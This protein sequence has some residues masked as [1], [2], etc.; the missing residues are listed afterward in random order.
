ML[1]KGFASE[2]FAYASLVVLVILIGML[3]Y[4]YIASENKADGNAPLG[5]AAIK[6]GQATVLKS[7]DGLAILVVPKGTVSD[8]KEI[9]IERIENKEI[10]SE[11]RV[12]E[13]YKFGPSG[14]K[15]SSPIEIRIGYKPEI[16]GDCPKKLDFYHFYDN[17]ELKET[18]PSKSVYCDIDIAVFEISSFSQGY[19]GHHEE[20]ERIPTGR[21]N[22]EDWD[23]EQPNPN[24]FGQTACKGIPKIDSVT[25]TTVNRG[26][27]FTIRGTY[28][29]RTVEFLDSNGKS[30]YNWANGI[31]MNDGRT[32]VNVPVPND[33]K[34]GKYRVRTWTSRT[35]TSNE[36]EITIQ[37]TGGTG[38]SGSGSWGGGITLATTTLTWSPKQTTNGWFPQLSPDGKY[39]T[40]G[41][42]ENWV[43]DLQTGEERSM[44]IEKGQS[45]AGHWIKPDAYTFM[46]FISQ[47]ENTA[48]RYEVKTGEWVARK[49]NDNPSLVAGNQFVAADSHWAS[50]IADTRNNNFRIAYDNQIIANGIGG[51]LSISEDWIVHATD[52]DNSAIQVW[53]NRQ[54]VATHSPQTPLHAMSVN[55]GYITYGGYGPV[56]G[57]NPQGQDIDLT[58]APWG[59]EGIGGIVF[60]NGQP[61]AYTSTWDEA[62]NKGFILIRP[63]GEKNSIVIEAAAV[64]VHVVYV[65][66]EFVVA[67]ND[68]KGNL[69]V[70][71]VP[72]DAQRVDLSNPQ[73][74]NTNNPATNP[75]TS[76]PTPTGS[77]SIISTKNL[78]NA[79]FP[80]VAFYQG[81]LY[82]AV[83]DKLYRS[84]YDLSDVALVKDFGY[85]GFPRLTVYNN[86]LWMA[87]RGTED[88][89]VTLW[90]SD[91]GNIEKLPYTAEGN[92]PVAA[93]YGYLA[94]N[95]QGS[96][97]RRAL[98]GG[99]V[100]DVKQSRPTGIN[101]ILQ[102][103]SIVSVDQ[104]IY[105]EQEMQRFG[106]NSYAVDWG[107]KPYVADD[108][109]VVEGA[110][111]GNLGRFN[112]DA[113]Y[114]FMVFDGEES[115]TPHA[116]AD[117]NGNYAI[118]T[119]GKP[120]VRVAV[121]KKTTTSS[122][123]V[124]STPTALADAT[125]GWGGQLAYNP[126]ANN[127]LVVSGAAS[128][129]I[130][131]NDGKAVT[132]EFSISSL[133]SSI[134]QGAPKVAFAP[135]M[136]KYLVVWLGWDPSTIYGRFVNADGT[137][138]G[139]IFPIYKDV[140]GEASYF[141]A[142]SFL[143]YD[144]K[145]KKFV[146]TWDV[147]RG[148]PGQI[149]IIT[150]DQ[151]GNIGPLIK[152]TDS[153]EL[154]T[155]EDWGRGHG[156]LAVNDDR[157]EYCI[158][159]S[160]GYDN[161][162]WNSFIHVRKMNSLTGEL[163]P[164]T[165]VVATENSAVGYPMIAY[166]SIDKNY[167]VAWAG[168]SEVSG[169]I[170]NSC[171]GQDVKNPIGSYTGVGLNA[172]SYNPKSNTYAAIGQDGDDGTN[173]GA[174]TYFIFDSSGKILTNGQVFLD[175]GFRNGNFAPSIA[176]N[177]QDGTFA[178]TSSKDYEIARFVVNIG[179][180]TVNSSYPALLC[181]GIQG[182]LCPQGYTCEYN[183]ICV[184][185]PDCG[186]TCKIA[187]I[188]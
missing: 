75:T 24:E 12:S 7:P 116:A 124:Q 115:F 144:Q 50:W 100:T 108:L 17:N 57:I 178:A 85:A 109:T 34:Y 159:Y 165:T 40:Y 154:R 88:N 101:R 147:A 26:K 83:D 143:R 139:D 3:G 38:P 148:L 59:W 90:R 122:S 176:A 94:F 93:G 72:A 161:G 127:W 112:N 152:A 56:H 91:T 1:K 184:G 27:S 97:R 74:T 145:N 186:G 47:A 182:K 160:R 66:N 137:F 128:G 58:V 163:G 4:S 9:S 172:V 158:V 155:T 114:Q 99:I 68:D 20:D 64:S 162:I 164:E 129:R 110:Q 6:Q 126:N 69:K 168:S 166:N 48:D 53:R 18:V 52:P 70:V 44:T 111:G 133:P 19:I 84:S 171:D 77:A 120:G 22:C 36:V 37:G 13:I 73:A 131:G 149:Y 28:L 8:T 45:F 15:F 71:K 76:N 175:S 118:A 134:Q 138:S 43:T 157:D 10:D 96:F 174:N 119:W 21:G 60:V 140:D 146:L 41:F 185:Q 117:G 105:P 141:K 156:V 35:S 136:N 135:D 62:Q 181:G 16:A 169:R 92:D 81:K 55:K 46:N 123:T 82:I 103:G 32:E 11:K 95:S 151:S 31:T 121:I 150:I 49:T 54:K 180:A 142:P 173:D 51:A 89:T 153:L 187:N 130:M 63:W 30:A 80:D 79:I 25:P 67:F 179:F 2:R 78:G 183:P 104:T 65:N 167:F 98:T 188:Q 14:A 113:N 170:I 86:I 23:R 132:P 61:W 87:Y 29:T 39:V 125:S 177:T 42:G 107:T 5:K 106:E 33:L 102:D